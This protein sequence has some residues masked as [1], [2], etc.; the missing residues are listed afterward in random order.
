LV[1]VRIVITLEMSE[2]SISKKSF[3]KIEQSSLLITMN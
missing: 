2:R 3:P 1:E